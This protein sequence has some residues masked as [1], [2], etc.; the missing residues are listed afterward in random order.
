MTTENSSSTD[1]A[2]SP[3]RIE[4]PLSREALYALVW[5]EPM[6]RVAAKFGVSSSYMARICTVMNVPRPERGYWAKLAVGKAQPIVPLPD[7]QPGDQLTWS[8]D[9]DHVRV[10]RALPSPPAR[11][12]HV[13]NV[14]AALLSSQHPILNGAKTQF[15]AGRESYE[16]KY[17]KPAKRLLVDLAVTKS[18]LEKAL[19]FAN[20]L[21]L[22]LED[23][24]HQVVIAPND[25]HFQR[26][27]VDEREKP[28]KGHLYN[29]LWSPGRVTVIYVG[30]V[31]IG[32]TIIEMSEEVEVRYVNGEYIRV[33]DYVPLKRGRYAA[34][35]T[36][37]TTKDFPTGH[38]CLQA[39]SPYPRAKWIHQWRESK[40]RDLSGQIRGIAKEL[41][42]AAVEIADLIKEGE[43]QARIEHEKWEAQ[44]AQWRR[45]E[46]ERLAAKALKDATDDI[47]RLIDHWAEMNR[48][49]QFFAAVERR[50]DELGNEERAHLMDRLKRARALIGSIDA[51]DYFLDWKAPEE[52]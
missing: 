45:E 46:T 23:N 52:R 6:L 11:V 1:P 42:Q 15:E 4:T 50:A 36:W 35:H 32:L 24:G 37:T 25:E 33:Q 26:A 28:H 43:R 20:Q 29:N 49:E 5:S 47:H 2:L 34:D 44:C 38:L 17:L 22:S 14:P 16:G 51:L 9:G 41:E 7:L 39:Y 19:A 18:G 40:D 13:V 8:R 27:A 30:T 10:P 48:I 12:K 3:E 31:A 21:F